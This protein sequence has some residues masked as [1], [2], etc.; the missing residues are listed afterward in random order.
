M[1]YKQAKIKLQKFY[2]KPEG[3]FMK[4]TSNDLSSNN[5]HILYLWSSGKY[6]IIFKCLAVFADRIV[7]IN[8]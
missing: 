3:T 2:L 1:W 8:Y 5:F 4:Q 7:K 6:Q